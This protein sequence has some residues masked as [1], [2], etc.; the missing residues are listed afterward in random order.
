MPDT[1][2]DRMLT[3]AVYF[4]RYKTHEVNQL[5]KV[6][7]AANVACKA[8]VARTDGAATKARYVE[9]MKQIGKIRDEAIG[10]IDKQ[11]EFDLRELVSA[12]IDFQEATLKAVG[13]K[14]ELTLPAPEK[15]YTAATYMPFVQ[16]QTF[17]K[18]LSD[19]SSNLYSQWDMS[20]R[21]GYLAGE[22]A[23]TINRRV[24]GSITDLQPGTMSALRTSLDK[25]TRTLLAH[26][27][28]QTR[29]AIYRKNEDIFSG[30]KYLAT[31]DGKTCIVC[32][33]DDGRVFKSIDVA[34]VLPRHY[35]DRCLYVPLIKGMNNDIGERASV[36]GPVD[37][38]VDFETWLR[39]Q[40]VEKQIEFLG[41]S[42]YELFKNGASLKGF[43]QDGRKLSLKNWK[44]LEGNVI[45]APK[46]KQ[47]RVVFQSEKEITAAGREILEQARKDN[48]DVYDILKEKRDF[49]S[50]ESH[51]FKK[52]SSIFAKNEI[53]NAQKYYPKDWLDK[54]HE[55]SAITPITAKK[56]TRGYYSNGRSIIALSD[57]KNC[58]VHELAHR[59]ESM[60]PEIVKAEKEFYNRRTKGE[61]F[62]TLR[63]LTKIN[64]PYSEVTKADKFRDPYMGKFY[65]GERNYELLSMGIEKIINKSYIQGDD[66]DFD[67]FIIGLLL[68]V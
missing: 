39:G 23:R 59:M 19:I 2:L 57:R 50:T 55:A 5:L 42:R 52:G 24:L 35:Y 11:L 38:K 4:E 10:K 6:L 3:H 67:A 29:D 63:S 64:Y 25:N 51:D 40:P 15:I 33:A 32:A 1:Y 21:V 30:Y 65:E 13:V 68:G 27:A 53:L 54:S 31:L 45:P 49:G 58:A 47:P 36:D 61:L 18:M 26:F 48:R 44:E 34:P 41:P 17:E 8:E 22:T 12:E 60:V 14:L 66:D 28:E 9:I 7:D 56:A 43:T 16:S 62:Q 20:V 37:G 46:Q